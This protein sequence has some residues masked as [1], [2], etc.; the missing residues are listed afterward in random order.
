MWG[1]KWRRDGRFTDLFSFVIIVAPIFHNRSPFVQLTASSNN[2]VFSHLS[3]TILLCFIELQ[4][5]EW[6][7]AV[8][9]VYHFAIPPPVICKDHL[10]L[11]HQW[12]V[13][14]KKVG[15][16]FLWCKKTAKRNDVCKYWSSWNILSDV[17]ETLT[18]TFKVHR[19]IFP[20]YPTIMVHF[21]FFFFYWLL[22]PTCGF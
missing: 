7:D 10:S 4:I 18:F 1:T 3:S 22:Q 6:P 21:F 20:W 11:K 8:L 14:V 17:T 15:F 2:T 9:H 13:E 19:K 5:W 16:Q 12:Y